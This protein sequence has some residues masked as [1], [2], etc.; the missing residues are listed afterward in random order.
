MPFE[1]GILRQFL[2]PTKFSR[3]GYVVAILYLLAGIVL[4]AFTA[5][6]KSREQDNFQ[7]DLHPNIRFNEA[8][9]KV[10][11]YSEYDKQYNAPLPL[12]GF[13]CLKFSLVVVV[14]FVYSWCVTRTNQVAPDFSSDEGSTRFRQRRGPRRVFCFYFLHLVTRLGLMTLFT[15]LETTAFFRSGFP[16]EFSCVSAT[17]QPWNITSSNATITQLKPTS[18]AFN[19]HNSVA[20]DKTI[21]SSVILALNTIFLV[22]VL[23]ENIYLVVRAFQHSNFTTNGEFCVKYL[24]NENG[25]CLTSLDF[26]DLIKTRILEQTKKLEPLSADEAKR[27]FDNI[28]IDLEIQQQKTTADDLKRHRRNKPVTRHPL[29]QRASITL[30]N[31]EELF[32]PCE[33]AQNSPKVLIVGR[34]GMGKSFL[35]KKLLRDW[36]KKNTRDIQRFDFTFLLKFSRFNFE[37]NKVLSL[38]DLLNRAECSGGDVGNDVIKYLLENPER[39]LLIFDGLDEFNDHESCAGNKEEAFLDNPTEKMPVFALYMKLLLEKLLRGATILTTCNTSATQ[40]VEWLCFDKTVE[41]MGFSNEQVLKY[42]DN[43]CKHEED[44]TVAQRIKEHIN[45]NL[46]LLQVCYIPVICHIV[47]RLLRDAISAGNS[48]S[49]DLGTRMTEVYQDVIRTFMFK[50]HPDYKKRP[51]QANQNVSEPV[52]QCLEKLGSLAKTGIAEGKMTFDSSEVEAGLRNNGLLYKLSDTRV[53]SLQRQERFC[54]I[55]ATFQCFLAARE[56]AK[57]DPNKVNE[58]I[59][60][61]A[62]DPKWHLVLQFVAGLLKRPKEH[63]RAPNSLVDKFVTCLQDSLLS[64]PTNSE[65]AL[66]MMKCLYEYNDDSMAKRAAYELENNKKFQKS[67]DLWKCHVK[68]I[69][70]TAI[71]YLVQNFKSLDSIDLSDNFIGE[72]GCQELASLVKNGGP[73][74]LNLSNNKITGKDLASVLEAATT[75]GSNLTELDIGLNNSIAPSELLKLCDLLKQRNCKLNHL[76][77]YGLRTTDRFCSKLGKALNH[78]YCRLT[79]LHLDSDEITDMGLQYLCGSPQLG[80]C[81]L[82]CLYLYSNTITDKGLQHVCESLQHANCKL[83]DLHLGGEQIT[84]DCF[85][86]LCKTL[87]HKNCKLKSLNLESDKVTDDGLKNLLEVFTSENYGL[88]VLCVISNEITDNVVPIV[89]ESIRHK[90]FKLEDFSIKS[91]NMTQHSSEQIKRKLLDKQ[92][93]ISKDKRSYPNV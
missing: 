26:S 81:K 88:T 4:V 42:V 49:V 89:G 68:P 5:Y 53:K 32:L 79:H 54:F 23:T 16:A 92:C 82:R 58:F 35:C 41:I 33:K 38:W 83:E 70:C 76:N 64:E 45:T 77:L 93:R 36:S 1:L 27:E 86:Y 72:G 14:C 8:Y 69:D 19:C 34:P 46:H 3:F 66:L 13:T 74:K 25:E 63:I 11:C 80:S 29:S 59:A 10:L 47:C 39:I 9:L 43:Y 7:C 2:D 55:H 75:T 21:V 87:K 57:M 84:N 50:H 52:E 20:R 37:T 60:S 51:C 91:S 71:V 61:N 85:Q 17:A 24:F 40:T 28:F 44:S 65:M 22:L 73:K 31:Y 18:Q 12:Y 56:I 78:E 30:N 62:K 90:N 6:L 48:E 15:V 67:I